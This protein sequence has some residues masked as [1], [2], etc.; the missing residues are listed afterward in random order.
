MSHYVIQKI[1]PALYSIGNQ[2]F[3]NV[4]QVIEFYKRHVLDMVALTTPIVRIAYIYP[5]LHMIVL[6]VYNFKFFAF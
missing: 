5:R 3:G 4:Y 6:V 1:G 2:Q